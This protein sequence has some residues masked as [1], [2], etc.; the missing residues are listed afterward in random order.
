MKNINDTSHIDSVSI[1]EHKKVLFELEE[2]QRKIDFYEALVDSIPIPT[3]AKSDDARFCVLNK[4]YGEYFNTDTKAL[5]GTSVLD[6]EHLSEEDRRRY[7]GEDLYAIKHSSEI[8][9]ETTFDLEGGQGQALYWSR[10]FSCPKTNQKGLVGVIV[11]ISKQKSFEANLGTLVVQLQ[12]TQEEV[13]IANERM[14]V[15]LDSMPLAAQVWSEKRE[16]LEASQETARLFGFDCPEAFIENFKQIVPEFQPD[17]SKSSELATQYIEEAFREGYVKKNWTQL[18]TSGEEI[19]LEATFILSSVHDEKVL[20]VFLRDLRE[21]NE[22]IRKLREA[23]EYT[24]LMLDASPFGTIIWNQ[25]FELVDCNQATANSF[26]V[27]NSSEFI[28]HFEK[29][30]PEF[31]ADGVLSTQRMQEHFEKTLHEG[32]SKVYWTGKCIDGNSIPFEVTTTRARH[33]D[34]FVVIAFMKDL[35]EVEES[36]R[37]A[38]RAERR[39]EAI[40][41]GIPLG[42]NI[43]TADKVII[44]CNEQAIQTREFTTKED[45]IENAMKLLPLA[46]PNG[47]ESALL[48]QEKFAEVDAKGYSRFE[49]YTRTK[50]G[51]ELPMEV[52]LVQA[53]IEHEELYISYTFDLRDT[54]RMLKEI[55]IAKEAAEQSAQAK[56]EFLANMS[57]EI[58]TPMNGILGLLHILSDTK[59]DTMQKDYMQKALFSTKELLRIINDILDFSK[60]EAGKLDMESLPFTIHDICSELESLFGRAMREKGLQSVM[61]EGDFATRPIMGDPLRLKQVLFN[62]VSNAIK[63]TGKGHIGLKIQSELRDNNTLFCHFTISDTGIGLTEGQIKKLFSAFSQ[64]DT[65]VTRKYG[66]TGLGLAI[67]KKIVNLMQGDIWVESTPGKGSNFYF[68]AIFTLADENASLPYS[69]ESLKDQE[70]TCYSGHLLLV[71]DNHI[72]QLIATEL[73]RNVGYTLDIA[74]NGQEALDMLEN[75]P[76]DLVL[77]DI[78]MPIMD[79]LTASMAIRNNPKFAHLPIVAMSAHAMTGDKEKSLQHGMNDHITKPISPDILYQTLDYWLNK[80]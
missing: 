24:K 68:T 64:A 11:D 19:P 1:D 37:K 76:Y 30:Y 55:E 57:H 79:G 9:Y 2:A 59:L 35:R 17:G 56:S 78:Q 69:I 71:E 36:K 12:K 75:H 31:Q 34:E 77:M 42:I 52:T 20:L 66:G 28:E 45:Y 60:I 70:K 26:G 73:L 6:L 74:N 50:K 46:Q 44:D 10:G 43:L 38:S 67:S 7:E 49:L 33:N 13:G 27:K 16:M 54:K 80:E 61:D 51:N 4:A 47:K 29:L 58:R 3:F 5:L 63:F 65:S 25:N 8:H 22:G 15:M 53:H 14:S 32:S 39:A 62:L 23:D 41:N 72:N 40:L 21:Q 48:I 18:N